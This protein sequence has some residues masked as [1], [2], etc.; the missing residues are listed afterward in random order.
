MTMVCYNKPAT[1]NSVA[2]SLEVRRACIRNMML[3]LY[4]H[5]TRVYNI[6]ARILQPTARLFGCIATIPIPKITR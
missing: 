2:L 6:Y 1:S 5:Y 3:G 4:V